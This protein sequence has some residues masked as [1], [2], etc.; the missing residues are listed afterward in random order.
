MDSRCWLSHFFFQIVGVILK[1]VYY[2]KSIFL[3]SVIL[4]NINIL[5]VLISMFFNNF[6]TKYLSS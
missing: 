1:N 5:V 6:V 3:Q 4:Y 2:H